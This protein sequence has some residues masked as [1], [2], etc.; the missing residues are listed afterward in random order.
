MKSVLNPHLLHKTWKIFDWNEIRFF[1]FFYY[2]E[3]KFIF[4]VA[5]DFENHIHC[6]SSA[7]GI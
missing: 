1:H 7:L 4:L 6:R 5:E 2:F 3:L